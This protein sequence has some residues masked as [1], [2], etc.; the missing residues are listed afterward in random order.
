M[1]D[2]YRPWPGA[3]T[4]LQITG[5]DTQSVTYAIVGNQITAVG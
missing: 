2:F 3:Y 4:R 1:F 5:N